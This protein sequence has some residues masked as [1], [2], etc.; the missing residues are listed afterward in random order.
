MN[1]VLS[2]PAACLAFSGAITPKQAREV[3]NDIFSAGRWTDFVQKR[4]APPKMPRIADLTFALEQRKQAFVACG[5]RS[6]GV[7]TSDLIWDLVLNAENGMASRLFKTVRGEKGLAYW[8]G[9]LRM[10]G[11]GAGYSAF[12]AS[13]SDD[14]AVEVRGMLLDEF[15]R[16]AADGL[17]KDE[18]DAALA[19]RKYAFDATTSGSLAK[20]AALEQYLI[21]DALQPWT[22]REQLDKLAR[23]ELN[24][25]LK[26]DLKGVELS[27]VIA[28]SNGD[29]AAKRSAKKA[30]KKR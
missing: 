22:R 20:Q 1:R 10:Y 7:E 8:T 23:A 4:P 26:R 28:Y 27:S 15:R 21:G 19:A 13:T 14:H 2:A 12:A 18:F 25:R 5:F 17:G 29:P 24:R 11:F 9:F 16:L 30:G 3:A 6:C